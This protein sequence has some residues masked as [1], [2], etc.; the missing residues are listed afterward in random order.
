MLIAP[1]VIGGL[2]TFHGNPRQ[3]PVGAPLGNFSP[4]HFQTLLYLPLSFVLANDVLCYNIVWMTGL[5]LTGL[6]T[7]LLAWHLLGHRACAAFAGLL[8]MLSAPMMIHAG[9]H[10]ELIYVGW[11]PI[12]L[13]WWMRF[14]DRPSPGR[15]AAAVLGYILVA[16]CAAYYMVFAVFPAVLYGIWS[17]S[18]GG[19]RGVGPWLRSRAPWLAGMVGLTLPCLLALF[20][21]HLWAIA[22]GFSL[23]RSRAEFNQYAAPLW[24]Y[25]TPTAR[26]LLGALL[27]SDAYA[28]LGA[29]APERTP[30]LGVVTMALLAYAAIRRVEVRRVSYLWSALILLVVLSLGA[31]HRVGAWEVSLPAAWLWDI[32]PPFRMTRVPSRFSLFVGVPAGVLAAAGLRDLLARLPG[33]RWRTTVFSGLAVVAV[34]DL[35]MIGIPKAP[36]PA[37]P[38]CY[39]FLKQL[40]PK[41]TLLEIPYTAAG[42]TYL[43]G[44]CTYWQS[45]HRLTTSA[46]YS[47]HDNTV[48][49]RLIGDNCPSHAWR[50]AQPDYLNDPRKIDIDLLPDVDFRDYL[51]VY[52]TVNQ[53]DYVVLHQCVASV[54]EYKMNLDRLKA[55]LQ[56]CKIYEDGA[57]IVYARSRLKPPARPIQITRGMGRTKLLA[58]P[59]ELAPPEDRPVRDLQPRPRA[60]LDAHPRRGGGTPG[61]IGP[62]PGKCRG[63]GPLG[64][65]ARLLSIGF[66]PAVPGPRRL[67]GTDDRERSPGPRPPRPQVPPQGGKEAVSLASRQLEDHPHA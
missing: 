49:E 62:R 56:D 38:G 57:S 17:A 8:A 47:G 45:L 50:L 52:L 64:G 15:L 16:M 66:Q 58:G 9:A 29:S 59:V 1:S 11:F 39:A 5:L 24:G 32:F 37:L 23:E 13:V 63:R 54:P 18:R 33:R 48:Q 30:Y 3:Y 27:P 4:L 53:F 42:G 22:H 35:A 44:E 25:V 41:A 26:H 20:S 67:A 51:W 7:S 28:S 60:R 65:Q 2:I 55:L 31:S 43:Y 46:G 10:L 6:G 40:D 12:F 21:G 19:L 14:V 34:A 36:P 61:P